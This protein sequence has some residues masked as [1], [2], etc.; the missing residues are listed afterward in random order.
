MSDRMVFYVC[1]VTA[2]LWIGFE[3]GYIAGERDATPVCKITC[4]GGEK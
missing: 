2:I 4:I 3:V 1:A